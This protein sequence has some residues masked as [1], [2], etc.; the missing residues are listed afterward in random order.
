MSLPSAPSGDNAG[1]VERVFGVKTADFS[2]ME[3]FPVS[4]SS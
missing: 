2:V 1:A 4:G 3:H